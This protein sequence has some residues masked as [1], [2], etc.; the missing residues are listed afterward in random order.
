MV[1]VLYGT[2]MATEVAYYTYIYAKVDR[3]RFQVVTG[4]TKSAILSGRFLA[5]VVAQLMISFKLMDVRQLNYLSL[6]CEYWMSDL[7]TKLQEIC[8]LS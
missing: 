8:Y 4:F 7:Y 2:Y 6:G 5:G 1:E 3:D